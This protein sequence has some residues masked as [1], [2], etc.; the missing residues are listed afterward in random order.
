MLHTAAGRNESLWILVASPAI[1]AA[2]FML[3]Y[4]T[5]AIWCA[6]FAGPDGSLWTIR[7]TVGWYTAAG[8]AAIALVG[9]I[10]L[11]NH[12]HGSEP[13]PHDADSPE[14]RQRFIGFATLLLSALSFVATVYTALAAVFIQSCR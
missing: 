13:P 9:W 3:C 14:D 4:V 6:K 12:R 10:G 2:H 5:A 11:R 1:W 8:L 7:T